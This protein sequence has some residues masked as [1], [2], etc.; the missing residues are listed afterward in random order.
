M[1]VAELR[2]TSD[3][4][5]GGVPAHAELLDPAERAGPPPGWRRAA[6]LFESVLE[7]F[8]YPGFVF[9]LAELIAEVALD[10]CP[11]TCAPEGRQCCRSSHVLDQHGQRGV[12]G[13]YAQDKADQSCYVLPGAVVGPLVDAGEREA[14]C[15]LSR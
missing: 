14:Q 4:R 10:R 6:D 3:E 15:V 9:E 13:E 2:T 12:E 8:S 7:L 5:L 1:D 11:A